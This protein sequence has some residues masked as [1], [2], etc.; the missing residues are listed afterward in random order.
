MP[1]GA[2]DERDNLQRPAQ[3]LSYILTV[4]APGALY[5]KLSCEGGLVEEIDD[6]VLFAFGLASARSCR[7]R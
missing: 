6:E 2:V 7:G 3:P 4:R 1:Q 5:D